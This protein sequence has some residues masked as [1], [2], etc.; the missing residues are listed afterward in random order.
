MFEVIYSNIF[1]DL[2]EHSASEELEVNICSGVCGLE[3]RAAAAICLG[4]HI[5]LGTIEFNL[6]STKTQVKSCYITCREF[7]IPSCS[8]SGPNYQKRE[9]KQNF[10]QVWWPTSFKAQAR[11]LAA[12]S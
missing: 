9:G 6:N 2:H 5:C 7:P 11:Y 10:E 3:W 1:L 12:Q 4:R 8:A